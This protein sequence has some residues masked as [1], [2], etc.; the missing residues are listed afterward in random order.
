LVTVN[1]ER[2]KAMADQ[3]TT[4]SK[5]RLGDLPKADVAA[6]TRVVCVQLG[7]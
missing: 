3:I 7:F 1:G 5:R 6:V 4:A 2:R